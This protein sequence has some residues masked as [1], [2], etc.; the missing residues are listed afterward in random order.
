MATTR[1]SDRGLQRTRARLAL[2]ERRARIADGDL[3]AR[4]IR[5]TPSPCSPTSTASTAASCTARSPSTTGS[6]CACAICS[7]PRT[8][9][10]HRE[11]A[12]GRSGVVLG[13]PQ[14]GAHPREGGRAA[15]HEQDL[16]HDAGG[17]RICAR[18]EHRRAAARRRSSPRTGDFI[19]G[20][21]PPRE[22]VQQLKQL[23]VAQR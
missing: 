21:M 16:R 8:G 19:D 4:R 11:L 9:P 2:I 6:A 17:A 13:G 10:E 15:R 14:R 12:Q 3:L 5:S 22:L 1:E 7:Y 23:Q 18:P 20:Y